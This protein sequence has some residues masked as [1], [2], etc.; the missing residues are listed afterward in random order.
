MTGLYAV[1][2]V[3]TTTFEDRLLKF[4]FN[5]VFTYILPMFYL[6]LQRVLNGY[7]TGLERVWN[8]NLP[9]YTRSKSVVYPFYIQAKHWWNPCETQIKSLFDSELQYPTMTIHFSSG[10]TNSFDHCYLYLDYLI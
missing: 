1:E 9:F 7:A 8:A 6:S 3:E 2:I 10:H 5:Q 4:V